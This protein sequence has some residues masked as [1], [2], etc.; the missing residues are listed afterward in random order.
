MNRP[1]LSTLTI[2]LDLHHLVKASSVN[3]QCNMSSGHCSL[4]CEH[5]VNRRSLDQAL[6]VVD[7]AGVVG[8]YAKGHGNSE[9]GGSHQV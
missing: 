6:C 5:S 4:W 9:E 8:E 3:T 2:F 1:S 7:V